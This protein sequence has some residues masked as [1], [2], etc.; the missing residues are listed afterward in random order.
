MHSDRS[1]PSTCLP[2]PGNS[3]QAYARALGANEV[4]W[5]KKNA[6]PRI[7]YFRSLKDPE[8]PEDALELL[9]MYKQ[10][11]PFLVPAPSDKSAATNVLWHP[12]LH[13]DNIFVDPN[14]HKYYELQTMKRVPLHW[15]ILQLSSVPVLKKPVW[16][17]TG[18]WENRDLFFLRDSLIAIASQWEDIFGEDVP[19]PIEFSEEE[20]D[21]HAKE[22]E[23]MDGV[24]KML[25]LLQDEGVLPTDGMVRPEDYSTAVENCRKYK[26]V[27]L[28]AAQNEE[29]RDLYSKLWT[30]QEHSE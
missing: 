13:L 2:K 6:K 21:L 22:G 19:C 17:V 25:S 27:F 15:D 10:I 7:N 12:D 28:A 29:E 26:E 30:Y 4:A 3:P 5:I 16:L 1:F 20:L 14:S 8:L 24:G 23:N 9:A 11:A 18:V